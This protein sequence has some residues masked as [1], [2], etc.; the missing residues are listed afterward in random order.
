MICYAFPL[1][2]EAG[3]LLKLCTQQERFSIGSLDCILANFR[4]RPILVALVG[5]GRERAAEN[6]RVIFRYFRP[7][8]FVLTGYAGAL[9]P[10]LKVG[11]VILSDN[12]TSPEVLPFLRLLSGFDFASFCTADEVVGTPEKREWYAQ[13]TNFQVVE[14]E[15]DAVA[16]IVAERG[17]PFMAVRVISDDYHLALP[18]G[19]LDAGFDVERGK[20]TPLRL[21]AYL[22]FHPGEFAPFKKFVTGLGV[23][24]KSLTVFL[25][26]LNDELPSSW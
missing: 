13:T 2:H 19:A 25:Q 3:E 5:M 12:L 11:Q 7:K 22:I 1:A 20:A 10:Q 26:Q 21:L 9:N 23:A 6:T 14:M 8:G 16:D 17:I 18:A 15:S 4:G 24:R